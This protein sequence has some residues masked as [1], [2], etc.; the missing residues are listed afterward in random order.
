MSKLFSNFLVFKY[1][2]YFLNANQTE[3]SAL[4]GKLG[5]NLLNMNFMHTQKVAYRIKLF[6]NC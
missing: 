1:Y 5:N 3:K 6:L 4:K 2:F